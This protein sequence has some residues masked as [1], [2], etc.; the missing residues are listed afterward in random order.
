MPAMLIHH[1]PGHSRLLANLGVC[2]KPVKE[3]GSAKIPTS[4]VRNKQ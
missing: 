1:V 2:H 4:L 3:L